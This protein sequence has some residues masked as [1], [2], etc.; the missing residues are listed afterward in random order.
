[1]MKEKIVFIEQSTLFNK[2]K[3]NTP[4]SSVAL[5]FK[6]GIFSVLFKLQEARFRIVILC[7][8]YNN[9]PNTL[10][11]KENESDWETS[12][13]VFKT[14]NIVFDEIIYYPKTPEP[15]TLQKEKIYL[16]LKYLKSQTL[17][18]QCSFLISD[19]QSDIKLA[20]NLG[21]NWLE[22]NSKQIKTWQDVADAILK[23]PRTAT[24]IRKTKETNIK[25][26]LNLDSNKPSHV[27]T[28][29]RFFDHLLEQVVMH[30]GINAS[31]EVS[32][33]LDV[34]DHHTI[35]DT[36]LSLGTAIK[37]ALGDKYGI[38]R[39]GF[40]LPM[41]EALASISLDLSGRAFCKFKYTPTREKVGDMATEMIQHFF[42]SF[43]D[44]LQVC[45]HIEV[46]G[47]NTHHCVE[48]MFKST[49]L[50]VKTGYKT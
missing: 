19:D 41:D 33:D 5:N 18:K 34:D 1:M 20:E 24:I 39:F 43:S 36:A 28:G 35:E 21:I 10:D 49:R 25:I 4:L 14:Q 3:I 31:I 2:N 47:E 8:Q 6:P 7:K 42:K 22:I 11:Q 32:G 38:E 29:I 48:A 12:I 15:I 16:L 30:A 50:R 13:E 46:K 45:L 17:S 37:E 23:K 44:G 27:T 9:S 40:S 26:D